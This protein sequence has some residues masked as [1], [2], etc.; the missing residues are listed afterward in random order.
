MN[1]FIKNPKYYNYNI[2]PNDDFSKYDNYDPNIDED[3]IAYEVDDRILPQYPYWVHLQKSKGLKVKK[4]PKGSKGYYKYK[5][6]ESMTPY[7]Y[8]ED[9]QRDLNQIRKDVS[10]S[11]EDD[12]VSDDSTYNEYSE[13]Y[14]NDDLSYS[15]DYSDNYS[16]NYSDSDSISQGDYSNDYSDNYSD[17]YSDDL[18]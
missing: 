16:D 1:R 4:Y 9:D 15:D 14:Y 5:N 17:N 6:K 7:Y 3:S 8:H 18:D 11:M 13:N 10:E 2:S 12:Y